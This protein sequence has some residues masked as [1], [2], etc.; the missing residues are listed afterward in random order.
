MS[1]DNKTRRTNKPRIFLKTNELFKSAF[2]IHGTHYT[3]FFLFCNK[4]VFS[5]IDKSKKLAIINLEFK[6]RK[7]TY[8]RENIE[9]RG[10]FD[11]NKRY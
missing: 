9:Y 2:K 8:E 1:L 10:R 6:K 7:K 3:S 4:F 5:I 11:K